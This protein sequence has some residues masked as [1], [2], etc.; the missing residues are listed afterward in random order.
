MR[1]RCI[2]NFCLKYRQE[3]FLGAQAIGR[4][5]VTKR[6]DIVATAIKF[7][8]TVE[9]LKDLEL[10]YAPPFTTAKD[11]VNYAG[12]V[13]SNLLNGDFKQVNV[14]RVRELVENNNIIIDVREMYEFKR[15]HI[16]QIR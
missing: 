3:E 2:L 15:G 5:D 16:K 7:G 1:Q 10:I 14:D 12:Y 11:I 6:I 13:G 4:G 9:D 8:G